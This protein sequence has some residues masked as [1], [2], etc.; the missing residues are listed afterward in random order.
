MKM[1]RADALPE[2]VPYVD[3]GCDV[4]PACLSCPLVRCRYDVEGG[5]RRMRNLQRD[6]EIERLRFVDG[7][8]VDQ[9]AERIGVSRRTVYRVTTSD[10]SARMAWA[11]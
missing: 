3:D 4:A 11:S 1:P 10:R 7:L 6:A 2:N 8:T 5:I 9:V